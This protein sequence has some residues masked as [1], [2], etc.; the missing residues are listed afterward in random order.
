MHLCRSK[1]NIFVI[2]IVFALLTACTTNGYYAPVR[3]DNNPVSAGNKQN[4]L[5]RK[6]HLEKNTPVVSRNIRTQ[7][8][9]T[10]MQP[11][12]SMNLTTRLGNQQP[13]SWN[14]KSP[15][16]NSAAK[17]KIAGS[18]IENAGTNKKKQ[19]SARENT[20]TRQTQTVNS[21]TDKSSSKIGNAHKKQSTEFRL[22]QQPKTQREKSIVSIDNKK[23]LE[24]S[25][26]WPIKGRVLKSYSPSRN[27]GI[28]IAGRNGQTV[29][30]AEAGKVV[31]GG[32]GLIGFGKLL[33]IKHNDVFLSAYANNS[34]LLVNEGELVKKGQ[35]VAEVGK[36][37]IKRTSLHFEIRE[38]G[39]PVNPLKFLP[40]K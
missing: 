29:K 3:T 25:F 18:A 37:G 11:F 7:Y 22:T 23:M 33:I 39:K 8:S 5:I 14:K 36:T 28:D 31:Y 12:H 1:F 10:N 4:P 16:D 6:R 21:A 9:A 17:I 13:A 19:N 2:L 15:A 40:K 24:L 34:L 27:K 20:L 35:I 26:C 38:N 32:Q 30:A